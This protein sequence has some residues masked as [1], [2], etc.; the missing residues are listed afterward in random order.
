METRNIGI[1]EETLEFLRK[2]GNSSFSPQQYLKGTFGDEQR[3]LLGIDANQIFGL[4]VEDH[5]ELGGWTAY[6]PKEAAQQPLPL[7]IGVYDAMA[8]RREM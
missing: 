3:E 2:V 1:P 7:V 8:P 5:G 6:L 4:K